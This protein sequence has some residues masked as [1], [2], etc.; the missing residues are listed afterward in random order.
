M[1]EPK[2][3]HADMGMPHVQLPVR[4]P[5]Y[6]RAR[7]LWRLAELSLY[8]GRRWL[9]YRLA[10]A[11]VESD[12]RWRVRRGWQPIFISDESRRMGRLFAGRD[13]RDVA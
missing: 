9:Y 10:V 1:S 7:L 13:E 8:S 6:L 4:N 2:P 5:H 11:A 12:N 3:S